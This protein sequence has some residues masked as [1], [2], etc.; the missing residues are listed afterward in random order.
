MN[1]GSND[2]RYV[3]YKTRQMPT[4]RRSIPIRLAG[5]LANRFYHCWN[6]GF[7]VDSE[8]VPVGGPNESS[9]VSIV[10]FVDSSITSSTSFSS[11]DSGGEDETSMNQGLPGLNPVPEPPKYM[12]VVTG[13]CPLCGCRNYR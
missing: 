6:C 10:P 5:D 2:S 13:G 9:G 1:D 8:A 3:R 11:G 4:Q 12:S 7:P